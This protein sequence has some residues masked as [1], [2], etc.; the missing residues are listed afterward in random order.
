VTDIIAPQHALPSTRPTA[1]PHHDCDK[2]LPPHVGAHRFVVNPLTTTTISEVITGFVGRALRGPL[3]TPVLL[4]SFA[5]YQRIFGGLWQ[6]STLSYAIE[7]YFEQGGRA[8]WVVR[9]ANGGAPATLCLPCGTHTLTLEARALGSREFLRAAVDYDGLRPD[10]IDCFNLV[11]QRVRQHHSEHIEEQETYRRVSVTPHTG[12]FVASA[13]I[14]SNLVRV[15]G[16]VPTQR[17]DITQ[18]SLGHHYA[19]YVDAGPDG[20][21]GDPLTDYDLIGSATDRTGLFALAQVERLD[22]LY[23]P[24]LTREQ[25]LG[26]SA[27]LVASR[28]CQQHQAMLIVDPLREWHSVSAALQGIR[29]FNFNSDQALMCFPR[30]VV[31]DR[32]RG[33]VETF[34]NGGAVAG[35]LSHIEELRPVWDAGQTEPPL[36]L[37]PGLRLQCELSE[38]D[39]WQ[40]AA[41]G[42]NALQSVRRASDVQLLRRTLA[43]GSQAAADWGYVSLRRFALYVAGSLL[44]NTRWVL[45]TQPGRSMWARLVKQVN[46][47]LSE[48]AAV[49]AFPG[50]EPGRQYFVVC[51]ERINPPVTNETAQISLLIGFAALQHEQYHCFLITHSLLGSQCRQVAVNRYETPSQFEDL[52][53]TNS[54]PVLQIG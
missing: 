15:R 22:Y 54:V 5:D 40:L 44:R 32:L 39:R 30:V 49:G 17:P 35:L 33:R 47:F 53:L 36:L 19:G 42:I 27:L 13:L 3:D 1:G 43:G 37:R 48:L 28:F 52:E 29:Q 9:V 24:P 8:A 45:L 20:S 18:R 16:D 21:D 11:V 25:D 51:D 4:R 50:A 31:Q 34:A 10:D 41:Q 6:P 23:L 7:H 14:E 26:M 12:R 38:T 46:G 2:V